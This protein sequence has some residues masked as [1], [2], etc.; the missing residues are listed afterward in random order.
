MPDGEPFKYHGY[1]G[2]CPKLPL[3][4]PIDTS[5]GWVVS[6]GDGDKW[7]SWVNGM[8]RWATDIDRATRFHRREDAEAVH[9]EDDDAWCIKPYK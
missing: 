5:N 9:A 2:P 4:Q 8:P 3:D 6:D 7:R 1:S